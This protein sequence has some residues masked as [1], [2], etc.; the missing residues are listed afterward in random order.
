MK[1]V[2]L[3]SLS[4]EVQ[5]ISYW[6]LEGAMHHNCPIYFDVRTYFIWFFKYLFTPFSVIHVK[7]HCHNELTNR[8]RR[9]SCYC[10]KC[11]VCDF[12]VYWIWYF[13]LVKLECIYL[14]VQLLSNFWL[15][16][17][18]QNEFGVYLLSMTIFLQR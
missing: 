16:R 5:V 11:F 14:M 6:C 4:F 9:I 7:I 12:G 18:T 2:I 8:A 3:V 17:W 15:T 10:L 1:V 13:C